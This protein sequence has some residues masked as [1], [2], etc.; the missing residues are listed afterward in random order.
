MIT[1]NHTPDTM[2]SKERLTETAM[3]LSEGYMRLF[4][5]GRITSRELDGGPQSEASCVK[6]VNA[7]ENRRKDVST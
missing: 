2:T 1:S 5:K 6:P 3:L 7:V 4:I